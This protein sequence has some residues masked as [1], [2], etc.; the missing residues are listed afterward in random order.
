MARPSVRF[1]TLIEHHHDEIYRYI[2][3]L[4][5]SAGRSDSSMEAQD[6][7]QEVFLRA[8]QAFARLR[9][10]SN[11]RAW[12]F[13]IATN[14]AY[15]TLKQGRRYDLHNRPLYDKVDGVSE[16]KSQSPD[17]QMI[18][19]EALASVGSFIASLPPKQG[20][21]VIL[22]HVQGLD[23]A[24]IAEAL[25]C[26][27]DSARANVYQGLRRLRNELNFDDL[28]WHPGNARTSDTKDAD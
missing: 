12:L 15:T 6:L 20:A 3:R 1:E 23:Y 27:E 5:N 28:Y 8:F 7:T 2:W 18:V 13:K 25:G 14:C 21:A 26:S 17:Q 4:L 9:S 11:H 22:R 10:D 16:G 19:D 24:E